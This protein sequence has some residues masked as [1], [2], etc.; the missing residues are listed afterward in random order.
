MRIYAEKRRADF[1]VNEK[2]SVCVSKGN[3]RDLKDGYSNATQEAV[4]CERA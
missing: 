1:M 2:P 4:G 3:G